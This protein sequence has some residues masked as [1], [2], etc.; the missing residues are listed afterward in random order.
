[1]GTLSEWYE[2]KFKDSSVNEEE[3]TIVVKAE[4]GD[5]EE[6]E[7][8][9][10]ADILKTELIIRKMHSVLI[11]MYN[12]EDPYTEN[13]AEK[14]KHQKVLEALHKKLGEIIAEL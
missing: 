11:S 5:D 13:V 6:I 14:Q 1:M 2:A 4:I 7:L 12:I 10:R 3:A 8:K 9:D